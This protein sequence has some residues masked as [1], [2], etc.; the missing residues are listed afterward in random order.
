MSR[1]LLCALLLLAAVAAR[2]DPPAADLIVLDPN[3]FTVPEEDIATIQ[4]PQ[5][6]VGCKIVYEAGGKPFKP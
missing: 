2:A 5:T 4:V 3:F 1:A 6:V